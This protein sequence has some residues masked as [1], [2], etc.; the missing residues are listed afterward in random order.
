MPLVSVV[1]PVFN[2][3][4]Y[5][6]Q[7]VESILR[8]TLVDL[9]LIVIDDGSTD[10]SLPGFLTF[11]VYASGS[12]KASMFNKLALPRVSTLSR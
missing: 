9:E 8:Q 10:A 12:V 2:G 3:Q 6:E 1:F 7:A 5:L 4:R 11:R